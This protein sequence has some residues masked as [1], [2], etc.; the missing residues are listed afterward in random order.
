[1]CWEA[2]TMS[3][4]RFFDFHMVIW[5]LEKYFVEGC[6]VKIKYYLSSFTSDVCLVF[7]HTQWSV[8]S[9]TW[10]WSP[11][12]RKTLGAI[13]TFTLDI[14]SSPFVVSPQYSV[15]PPTR[16]T[17]SYPALQIFTCYRVSPVTLPDFGGPD[18]GTVSGLDCIF[19]QKNWT[20][21]I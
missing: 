9:Q 12:H 13:I 10:G 2:Q 17:N 1:M 19:K 16:S 7:E 5:P 21:L 14:Q 20:F 4:S 18:G 6:V 8:T 15:N 11:S 3:S